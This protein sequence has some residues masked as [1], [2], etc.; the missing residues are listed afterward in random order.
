MFQAVPASGLTSLV[1]KGLPSLSQRCD[2]RKVWLGSGFG[3]KET[4]PVVPVPV[5][6][7]EKT[8][9]RVPFSGSGSLPGPSRSCLPTFGEISLGFYKKSLRLYADNVL[10]GAKTPKLMDFS[11]S[12]DGPFLLWMLSEGRPMRTTRCLL[13][14][15]RL[16]IAYRSST[17]AVRGWI[18]QNH[19]PYSTSHSTKPTQCPLDMGIVSSEVIFPEKS[20]VRRPV[21]SSSFFPVWF[22]EGFLQEVTLGRGFCQSCSS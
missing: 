16:D 19:L 6:A 21:T 4:I 3:S 8:I 9:L 20:R 14:M 12:D 10:G 5:S 2:S 22:L 7:P 15:A 1:R 13:R 18:V 11:F 17:P